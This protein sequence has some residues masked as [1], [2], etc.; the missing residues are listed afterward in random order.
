VS[1]ISEP[2]PPTMRERYRAQVRQEVK[3]AALRQIAE[4]GPGGLSISAIGKQL[5]VSGPALYR[6]FASRD[7]L[8]T[9]LVI[10]AYNDLADALTAATGPVSSHDPRPRFEALARA[11]RSWA[12]TQPHRYQLL[13]GPP[14]PGYEAH[15]QRLIDAAQKA[16]NLLLDVLGAAGDHN[17]LPPSQPLA[18]QLAAWAQPHHPGINPAIALRAVL[19]WSRLHGIVSLEIAGN[20]ASMGLDPGQLFEIQLAT[21]TT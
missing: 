15:A 7:D 9:E 17:G 8:L 10:D 3:E 2:E 1:A 12:L 18:S 21:L 4:A 5:G 6:Y 20:F 16:M 11:Y 13:F 14:L 19:A